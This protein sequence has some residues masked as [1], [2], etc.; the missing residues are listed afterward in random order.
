MVGAPRRG[1]PRFRRERAVSPKP[2]PPAEAPR[3]RGGNL[4][5]PGILPRRAE[6]RVSRGLTRR[7][8]ARKKIRCRNGSPLP[9]WGSPAN[10]ANPRE[11]KKWGRGASPRGPK[12]QARTRR[13]PQPK[14]SRRDAGTRRREF[15]EHSGFCHAAMPILMKLNRI[16]MKA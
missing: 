2:N 10:H 6:I 4:A 14:S 16:Y 1:D 5:T 12:I 11:S 9:F 3:R 15:W 13:L 7:H 8:E